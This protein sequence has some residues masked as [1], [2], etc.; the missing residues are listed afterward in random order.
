MRRS[1][2]MGEIRLEYFPEFNNISEKYREC[3]LN[4]VKGALPQI[5]TGLTWLRGRAED[6]HN[7]L[8][9]WS[10]ERDFSG[11]MELYWEN[12]VEVVISL[13]DL[14]YDSDERVALVYIEG[15]Y[16]RSVEKHMEEIKAIKEGIIDLLGGGRAPIG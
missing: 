9:I 3:E 5:L 16:S 14:D 13:Y 15:L 10:T 2:K 4:F 6:Y 12:D 7:I 11:Y 1:P 8:Q